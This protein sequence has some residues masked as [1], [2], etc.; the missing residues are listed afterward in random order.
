MCIDDFDLGQSDDFIGEGEYA[1]DDEVIDISRGPVIRTRH[2]V[3][4]AVRPLTKEDYADIF[5]ENY[6]T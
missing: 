3:S 2:P 5:L 1:A 6:D 4:G